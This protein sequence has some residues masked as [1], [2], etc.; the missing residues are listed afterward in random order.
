MCYNR[1]FSNQRI[2]DIIEVI[3]QHV[4]VFIQI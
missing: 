2:A 3:R 4:S 1:L